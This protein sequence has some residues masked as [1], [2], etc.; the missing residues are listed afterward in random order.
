MSFINNTL[1]TIFSNTEKIVDLKNAFDPPSNSS[2]QPRI[3]PDSETV[4]I[5][6]GTGAL[7]AVGAVGFLGLVG[8]ILLTRK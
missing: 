6:T 1:G 7:V 5:G 4:G 2:R 3:A 8:I